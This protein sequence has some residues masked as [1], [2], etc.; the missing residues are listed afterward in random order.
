[1]PRQLRIKNLKEKVKNTSGISYA[2][3]SFAF[4]VRLYYFL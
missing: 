2:C 1:M 4:I 3:R